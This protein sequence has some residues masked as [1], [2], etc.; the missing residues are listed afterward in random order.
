MLTGLELEYCAKLVQPDV[1][2]STLL[3][4]SR[5]VPQV[6]GTCGELVAVEYASTEPLRASILDRRPWTKRVELAIAVLDMIQELERT[7]Y[8][9]LYICDMQWKNLGVVRQPNE[10][11]IIKSIDNDKSFFDAV[12]EKKVNQYRPC[13]VDHDCRLVGCSVECNQTTH[14]CSHQLNSNNLQVNG[15]LGSRP[16]PYAFTLRI[17]IMRGREHLKSVSNVSLPRK[18]RTQ[19]KAL[20]GSPGTEAR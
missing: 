13:L 5:L 1:I 6:H 10:G 17:L 11:I 20:W 15:S 9:T 19:R 7:P 2:L 4:D 3:K 14:T 12:V 18:S 8:G 16:S